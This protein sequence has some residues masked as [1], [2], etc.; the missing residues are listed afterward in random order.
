V[1]IELSPSELRSVGSRELAERWREMTGPIA[2]E[3]RV[4]FVSDGLNDAPSL[5]FELAGRDLEALVA[6]AGELRALLAG[7]TGVRQIEDSHRPG[8]RELRLRVKPEGE[9]L[10]LTE[11]ELARQVRQGFQGERV[12]SIPRG[13]EE[14]PVVV[15]YPRSG[16]RSLADLEA[17]RVRTPAGV[18][19]P[20]PMVASV[21]PARGPATI[22]RTDRRR[23]LSVWAD[24]DAAV[25]SLA[26]VHAEVDRA[27]PAILARY[28]SVEVGLGGIS[29]EQDEVNES[30]SRATPLA[31]LVAY[32]LLAVTMRSYT[33]PLL[34]MVAL[35]FGL[36][37]AIAAH[38]VLGM[39]LSGFSMAGMIALLGVVVNDSLV[40][41]DAARRAEAEGLN[42]DDALCRAGSQRFRAIVLTSLTT[43][44]GLLP[45]LFERSSQ[46]EWLK[47][48]AAS[49]AVGV[50]FATLVTLLVVPAAA[51]L[52][53]DV[54]SW[55]RRV[56]IAHDPEP[57]AG[58]D[59][60]PTL[61]GRA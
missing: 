29:R 46:S 14:V 20:L 18:E 16:R 32:V 33:D 59:E 5:E 58:C 43:F 31:V 19:V 52:L 44:L 60:A 38:A 48:V 28:P 55:L 42:L 25:I 47:P 45:L 13:R 11:A 54:R 41:L 27:L 1:K 23:T 22:Q 15:R 50:L 57:R 10:G 51:R 53:E 21:E 40:F 17:A 24:V 2:G 36:A 12:Q 7:L 49:L 35:P 61:L 26:D 4:R 6:V 39:S 30:R 9:A 37:G 8:K 56:G 34:V 3:P